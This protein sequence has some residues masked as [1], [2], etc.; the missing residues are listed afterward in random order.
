MKEFAM[1][2]VTDK[3]VAILNIPGLDP[4]E[5]PILKGTEGPEVIDVRA[6]GSHGY[7][8]YDP[9]FVSTASCK[10]KITFIDG[11]KGILLHRGYPIA[12]LATQTDYLQVCYLLLNGD[13]PSADQYAA[14]KK[15]VFFREDHSREGQV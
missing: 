14:F 6:L 7:F 9:G 2:E 1:S 15:R 11:E 8:T 13:L 5:L 10:S 12:Q 4:I 3:K